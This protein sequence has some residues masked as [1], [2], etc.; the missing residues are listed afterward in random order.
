MVRGKPSRI[1]PR[2]A[3]SGC[4][5]RSS[6]NRTT[7]SSGTYLPNKTIR[8]LRFRES[9]EVFLVLSAFDIF[10]CLVTELSLS[11]EMI[12]KN[13]TSAAQTKQCEHSPT[14]SCI[15]PDMR[16][17]LKCTKLYSA[18]NFFACV[19]FPE[20][21][22]PTKTKIFPAYRA[23]CNISKG[24]RSDGGSLCGSDLAS[25]RSVCHVFVPEWS[26]VQFTIKPF[27]L[28]SLLSF[29]FLR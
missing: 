7:S 2:L 19:P 17:D 8:D 22:G 14:P 9:K 4:R 26:D 10:A 3:T 27:A 24:E 11:M 12:P 28:L 5:S 20:Q 6:T 23:W 1:Q 21:G 13:V 16:T 25:V 29:F 18:A 15:Q